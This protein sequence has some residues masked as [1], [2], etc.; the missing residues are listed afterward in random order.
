[1]KKRLAT[2]HAGPTVPMAIIGHDRLAVSVTV[3]RGLVEEI[4]AVKGANILLTTSYHHAHHD[5][6]RNELIER[7]TEIVSSLHRSRGFQ[8]TSTTIRT[9]AT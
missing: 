3:P 2:A 9:W 4:L 1:M 8:V 5:N 7:A 6:P